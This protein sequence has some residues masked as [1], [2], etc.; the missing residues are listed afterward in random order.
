MSYKLGI[1]DVSGI[2]VTLRDFISESRLKV[3]FEYKTKTIHSIMSLPIQSDR[4]VAFGTASIILPDVKELALSKKK[5]VQVTGE[6]SYSTASLSEDQHSFLSAD[7]KSFVIKFI[8]CTF[9]TRGILLK[10]ET[11]GSTSLVM[12]DQLRARDAVMCVLPIRQWKEEKSKAAI[13]TPIRS[14][15]IAKNKNDH[16]KESFKGALKRVSSRVS[17]SKKLNFET[18]GRISDIYNKEADMVLR[19]PHYICNDQATIRFNLK[20]IYEDGEP[21]THEQYLENLRAL[22]RDALSAVP[23]QNSNNLN[24]SNTKSVVPDTHYNKSNS[25]EMNESGSIFESVS[26]YV[27]PNGA[28]CCGT[29]DIYNSPYD[30]VLRNVDSYDEVTEDSRFVGSE[31]NYDWNQDYYDEVSMLSDPTFTSN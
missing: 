10:E 5:I 17:V 20:R 27:F 7:Q 18:D 22:S 29:T 25:N 31:A 12:D 15:K 16:W 1:V 26:Q 30:H 23:Q 21:P 11:V 8:L 24:E 28:G 9:N 19:Q 14:S 2:N 3:Q 13:V 6:S 4:S